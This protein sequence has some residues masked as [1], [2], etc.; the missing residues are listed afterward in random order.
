MGDRSISSTLMA[1]QQNET[2]VITKLE[3]I[4]YSSMKFYE[5]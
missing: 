2:N 5:F 3:R 4:I 1:V